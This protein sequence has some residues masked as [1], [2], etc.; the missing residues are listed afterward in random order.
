[1]KYTVETEINLPIARVVELFDD[2]ENLKTLAAG[3]HKL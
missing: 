2:P 1:M 3:S